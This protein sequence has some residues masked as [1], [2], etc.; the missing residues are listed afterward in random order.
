MKTLNQTLTDDYIIKNIIINKKKR[1]L[2]T[3][4][5][6]LKFRQITYNDSKS[7]EE[8]KDLLMKVENKINTN[9]FSEI[10][11]L[12][13]SVAN[14]RNDINHAGCRNSSQK[15]EKLIN[16]LKMYIEEFDDIIKEV[17]I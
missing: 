2:F 12:Y 3:N 14:L 13:D 6:T 5:I 15:S 11:K 10:S 9:L 1:K 17:N 4:A 8:T 7:D 16:K